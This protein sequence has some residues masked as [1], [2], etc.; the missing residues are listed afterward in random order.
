MFHIIRDS[1]AT[2]MS[3]KIFTKHG[4]SLDSNNK[5]HGLQPRLRP[6]VSLA[7]VDTRGRDWADILTCHEK[8]S[9]VYVS[10]GLCYC[11]FILRI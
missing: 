9:N 4:N 8:D 10:L 2:E 5:F 1:L 3:Q 11:D 6:L 7:A